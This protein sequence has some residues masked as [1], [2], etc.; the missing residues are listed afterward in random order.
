MFKLAPSANTTNT[1]L[2]NLMGFSN[3]YHF[4]LKF[5]RTF[6]WTSLPTFPSQITSPPFGLMS[7]DSLNLLSS[8]PYHRP[9]LLLHLPHSLF[10]KFT[11]YMALLRPLSLTATRCLSA[12]FGRPFLNS[13]GRCLAFSS[14]YHPQTDGQTEVLNRC[15]ETYLRC[16]VSEEPRAWLHFLPLA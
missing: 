5:G 6:Q 14:S 10:P 8:S 2:K 3:R 15:L 9:S 4:L 16:F 7:I 13:F 12:S 1:P 11:G